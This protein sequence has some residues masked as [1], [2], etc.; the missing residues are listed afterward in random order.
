MVHVPRFTHPRSSA[1]LPLAIV[2]DPFSQPE[3]G[4]DRSPLN[5]SSVGYGRAKILSIGDDP[6]LLYSRRLV[7]ES[8]GYFV[9][10][11]RSDAIIEAEKLRGFDLVVLC[12]SIPEEMA[13]HI[14]DALWR[15]APNT[16]VLLVTRFDRAGYTSTHYVPVSANPA[17]ML[18]VVA[19]QLAHV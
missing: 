1:E 5:E 3:Q 15:L 18:T 17:A 11:L 4:M 8:E 13:N 12:H 7:L 16:P 9:A 2:S 10:S 6:L 14:L 19:Q